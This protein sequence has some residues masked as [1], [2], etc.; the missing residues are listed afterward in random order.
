M[1]TKNMTR[2]EK[3]EGYVPTFDE[4][5]NKEQIY[6]LRK[7]CAAFLAAKE[8]AKTIEVTLDGDKKTG[9]VGVKTQI[10]DLL[11]EV[12][13]DKVRDGELT[14][15]L[16]SQTRKSLSKELLLG[17]GVSQEVLDRCMVETSFETLRVS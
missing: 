16:V 9:V 10:V 11:H 14:V 4:V 6:S 1:A 2:I 7:L 3:G 17:A 12:S 8:K 15:S 13:E 5:F